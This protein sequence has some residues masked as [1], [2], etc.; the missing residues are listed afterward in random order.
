MM[1]PHTSDVFICCLISCRGPARICISLSYIF[2]S[3]DDKLGL[4]W[5][6]CYAVFP[7]QLP[8]VLQWPTLCQWDLFLYYGITKICNCVAATAAEMAAVSLS[9]VFASSFSSA[10]SGKRV[11][12]ATVSLPWLTRNRLWWIN[13][14]K[15]KF[16]F[17]RQTKA[18]EHRHTHTYLPK[19]SHC[20]CISPGVLCIQSTLPVLVDHNG[21]GFITPPEGR[22]KKGGEREE[23]CEKACS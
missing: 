21:E 20:R 8:D 5:Y 23:A 19:V 1:H 13:A 16:T 11:P 9:G 2:K 10:V 6:Y 12:H 14:S 22:E 18:H 7:M 3:L 4:H 17:E 15:Q